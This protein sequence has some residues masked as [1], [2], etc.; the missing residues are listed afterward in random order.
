[1]SENEAYLDAQ[2]RRFALQSAMLDL[3]R[4]VQAPAGTPYWLRGLATELADLSDA[5]E[6]H[7]RTVEGTNGII[8]QAVGRAPRT[9]ALG[10]RLRDD[11]PMLRGQLRDVRALVARAVD[12]GT[13]EL[14]EDIRTATAELLIGLHRHRAR[15]SDFVWEAYDLDIGGTG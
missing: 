2:K 1:M 12:H 5:L 11:H 4:S 8:E 13:E 9:A 10:E 15:G 6:D 14:V 3:E 7:I